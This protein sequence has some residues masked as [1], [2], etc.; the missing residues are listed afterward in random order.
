MRIQGEVVVAAVVARGAAPTR[1]ALVERCET[2]GG[3]TREGKPRCLE[4]VLELEA[5]R[6]ASQGED[7]RRGERR[8]L[9]ARASALRR[10]R[11][12]V[13]SGRDEPL[14]R[15]PHAAAP[16]LEGDVL[17]QLRLLGEATVRH[18]GRE[19]GLSA[20]GSDQLARLLRRR[21]EVQTFETS[22]GYP[23]VRLR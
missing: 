19:L 22:R 20:Q 18:L 13:L 9:E 8:A 10:N 4:H 11:L 17:D 2:C 12:R 15:V 1:R 14:E 23:A 21:P 16:T 3:P 7:L 6:L 5:A